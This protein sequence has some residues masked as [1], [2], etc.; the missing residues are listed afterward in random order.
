MPNVMLDLETLGTA[1]TSIVLSVGAVCDAD[2]SRTFQMY[3]EMEPQLDYG[4]TLS[5]STLSW[6]LGQDEAARNDQI[7]AARVRVHPAVAFRALADWMHQ[8]GDPARLL[9]WG[10]GAGFDVPIVSFHM[11]CN[12]IEKPWKFW[13]ERC[14]R[15]LKSM[16]PHVKKPSTNQ[17]TALGD[18]LNQMLHL[19][20]LLEELQRVGGKL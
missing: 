20:L 9:L 17:H 6:W 11:D 16:F 19:Q 15:T 2:P 4:A 14:Y 3:L 10:N 13:N 1:P 8:F 7:D 12:G 18:A 5:T